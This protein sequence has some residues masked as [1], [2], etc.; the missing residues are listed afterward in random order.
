MRRRSS[1]PAQSFLLWE[2]VA[3][4]ACHNGPSTR[5]FAAP[6][7]L[8][9]GAGRGELDNRGARCR[10][11]PA[12]RHADMAES[13]R[14]R[15]AP[16][17]AR[18]QSSRA[19]PGAKNI[20]TTGRARSTRRRSKP[21]PAMLVGSA[22]PWSTTA[23]FRGWRDAVFFTAHSR[24]ITAHE[25]SERN[26]Q[27]HPSH[28]CSSEAQALFRTRS[29]SPLRKQARRLPRRRHRGRARGACVFRSPAARRSLLVRLSASAPI[30][31]VSRSATPWTNDDSPTCAD[32]GEYGK[33]RSFRVRRYT[34]DTTRARKLINTH[35]PNGHALLQPLPCTAGDAFLHMEGAS[36]GFRA[37]RSPAQGTVNN[38]LRMSR[39]K[40]ARARRGR[41]VAGGGRTMLAAAGR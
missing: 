7:V 37:D 12:Q 8:A 24:A 18:L 25:C 1:A 20:T 22:D 10:I 6:R 27:I 28:Y 16:R 41:P 19:N 31:P 40:R 15:S 29:Q 5:I 30:R 35:E 21:P 2:C 14:A 32:E 17:R 34:G 4:G 23:A 13:P 33:T 11:D 36:W 38:L 9:R 39:R 3:V 26:I